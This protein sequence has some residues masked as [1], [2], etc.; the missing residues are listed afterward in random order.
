M[1]SLKAKNYVL[2]SY[3]GKKTFKGSSLRSRADE[4]FGQKFLYAGVDFLLAGDLEG[5]TAHY[6]SLLEKIE[7]RELGIDEISRRERVTEKTFSSGAK[8][9]AA[10]AMA[11]MK[12]GDYLSLYQREGDKALVPA[13]E[14]AGD[15]DVEYYQTKLHK[16]AQRLEAAVGDDFDKLFPKPLVGAKRKA[17]EDAKHQM[18]LFEL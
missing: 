3:E 15:E 9:R 5:L 2:V 1:L 14:Y 12:V 11:G 17:A 16:F 13:T 6:Q 7:N 18:S 8:Q 4:R 10:T